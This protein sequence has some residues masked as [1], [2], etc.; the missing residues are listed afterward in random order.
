MRR[1]AVLSTLVAFAVAAGG[2]TALAALAARA[3]EARSIGAVEGA[4]AAEGIDFARVDVDGLVL[5]LTGTA[6]SEA[7]RFRAL[8]VAGRQVDP[9]RIRDEM[10]VEAAETLPPPRFALELLRNG[11]EVTLIGLVPAATERAVLAERIA[12]ATGAEVSDL[13]QSASH[14]APEGW[15]E[16]INWTVAALQRLPRSQVSVS[17]DLIEVTAAA[18]SDG[19]RAALERALRRTVPEG[20]TLDLAISAPRPVLSPFTLLFRL[21]DGA[22]RMDACSADTE[23]AAR[24][25]LAAASAA[26]AARTDCTLGLGVPSPRWGEAAAAAIGTLAEIGG[27]T[28]TFAD[29]A[30]TLLATAGTDAGAFDEA[31]GALEAALPPAFELEAVLPAIPDAGAPAGPAEFTATRGPEGL[32]RLRGR[33]P[34][35]RVRAA[36]ESVAAARFGAGNVDLRARTDERLPAEWGAGVMAGLDALSRLETGALRIEPGAVDLRGRTGDADAQAEIAA[37]LAGALGPDARIALEVAYDAALDPL[38]ALPSP[39]ACIEEVRGAAEE[40]K[41][42]FAPG[43]ADIEAEG[44]RTVTRIATILKGCPPLTIDVAAHSDSQGRESMNLELSQARAESVVAALRGLRV[45]EHDLVATGYGEARPIADNGTAEGREAN[46]R[47]EFALAGGPEDAA[48]EA[49]AE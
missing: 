31:V 2:A 33:L 18:E 40:G 22:A 12:L 17:A 37:L 24:R 6:P 25:I 23:E 26:G 20:A 46:R 39:E 1:R 8:T 11:D 34:D 21:E 9:A 38:A 47:I 48:A 32:V 27:G 15:T 7:G 36:V 30:V 3:I 45:G 42:T 43:S 10:A 29:E 28:V 13:L 14:E 44:R 35:E 5:T 4:L 16:A 19:E 41:I 49:T